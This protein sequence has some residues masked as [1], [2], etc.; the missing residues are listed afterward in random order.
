MRIGWSHGASERATPESGFSGLH[1]AL[2]R[3]GIEV[4]YGLDVNNELDA[5]IVAGS[6]R[7]FGPEGV[8][9]LRRWAE[10][11]RHVLVLPLFAPEET[12]DIGMLLPGLQVHRDGYIELRGRAKLTPPTPIS[13]GSLAPQGS[14]WFRMARSL[15]VLD[16]RAGNIGYDW[17]HVAVGQGTIGLLGDANRLHDEAPTEGPL[18]VS[19][20]LQAWLPPL[21]AHIC[22][23]HLAGRAVA[24]DEPSDAAEKLAQALVHG[25]PVEELLRP[26]GQAHA[27][28][29]LAEAH[30]VEHRQGRVAL[31]AQGREHAALVATLLDLPALLRRADDRERGAS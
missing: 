18:S 4:E 27:I 7:V 20:V 9:A 5:F 10:A 17:V 13:A 26:G 1:R 30:L 6:Q 22:A 21:H 24:L 25:V 23:R 16:V 19:D 2:A 28:R 29:A 15:D 8:R 31:T 3:R 12:P 11:G 14:G